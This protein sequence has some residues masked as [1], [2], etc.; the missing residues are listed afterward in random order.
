MLKCKKKK[1]KEKTRIQIR[2]YLH[3]KFL[4]LAHSVLENVSLAEGCFRNL[5][6]LKMM[7]KSNGF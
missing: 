4:F 2:H 5:W 6:W 1:K 3:F 7:E